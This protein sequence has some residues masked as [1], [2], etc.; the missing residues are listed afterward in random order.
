MGKYPQVDD[1]DVQAAAAKL[2]E[3]ENLVA[4]G[5]SEANAQKS[6]LGD[7]QAILAKIEATLRAN[8]EP[9]WFPAPFDNKQ[10]QDWANAS[11][12]AKQ[13]AQN[14]I[15]EL[16]RIAPTAH[17]PVNRGTVQ[18]GS[19]YDKQDLDRLLRFATSIVS[20]VD[21]AIDTTRDTLKSQFPAQ[22]NTLN[23][24]RELDPITGNWI[25]KTNS[26]G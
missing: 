7:V 11:A 17:L 4:F 1:P 24:Y 14:A 8:R 15:A 13:T 10:A 19:P 2:A 6:S 12:N 18:D 21:E 26:T 20:D 16:Q 22:D 3:M 5:N 9:R 25:P 23:Y